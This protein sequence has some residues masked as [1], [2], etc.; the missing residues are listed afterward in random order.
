MLSDNLVRNIATFIGAIF[1]ATVGLLCFL[2]P[3]AV[4]DFAMRNTPKKIGPVSNPFWDWMQTPR[5]IWSL[6][7]VGTIAMCA[8]ILLLVAVIRSRN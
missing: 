8:L 5:Y 4:R 3:A 1:F 2:W 7:I 6:R